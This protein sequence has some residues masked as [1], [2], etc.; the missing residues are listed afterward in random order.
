[1]EHPPIR[2]LMTAIVQ[3]QD[4]D[5][6]E[7]AL[8]LLDVPVIHLPSTGGF[9]GRRNATLFIGL[10][11]G[12]EEEALVTL[13]EIL[14]PAYGILGHPD[15]GRTLCRSQ[16]PCRLP[17]AGPPFLP[18]LWNA[19]RRFSHETHPCDRPR[20]PTLIPSARG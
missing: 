9:L 2:Y 13:A 1:M 17:W 14:P 4:V 18:Y 15:G 16:L 20:I 11:E 12:L 19:T 3:E 5:V 8:A 6:A 10:P 7:R